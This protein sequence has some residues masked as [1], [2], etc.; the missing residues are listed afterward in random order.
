MSNLQDNCLSCH[1]TYYQQSLKTLEYVDFTFGGQPISLIGCFVES[2]M[3]SASGGNGPKICLTCLERLRTCHFTNKRATKPEN[4][5]EKLSYTCA[6][7]C[8]LGSANN[9]LDMRLTVVNSNGRQVNL[10]DCV[11]VCRKIDR[12]PGENLT[13]C[14]SCVSVIVEDFIRLPE[15][16]DFSVKVEPNVQECR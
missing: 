10:E 7:C 12:M 1:Q 3:S 6:T 5:T 16:M 13:I 9:M 8:Q 14:L 15:F 4:I 11:K 2:S